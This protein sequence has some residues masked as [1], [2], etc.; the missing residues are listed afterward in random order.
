MDMNMR[1]D[2]LIGGHGG[3]GT[4]N[5]GSGI[6]INPKWSTTTDSRAYEYIDRVPYDTNIY[7]D[8]NLEMSNLQT[9]ILKLKIEFSKLSEINRGLHIEIKTLEEE[10]ILLKKKL[11]MMEVIQD[12]IDSKIPY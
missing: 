4:F 12:L 3:G 5:T 7:H 6:G 11:M 2:G 1:S 8:N 10:N 9:K